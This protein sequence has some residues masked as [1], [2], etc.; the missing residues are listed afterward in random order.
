MR[1]AAAARTTT[2]TTGRSAATATSARRPVAPAGR[3]S[4]TATSRGPKAAPAVIKAASKLSVVKSTP[5]PRAP[6]RTPQLV[7]K[8]AP[9]KAPTPI[10]A[11]TP[12]APPAPVPV[13]P[14]TSQFRQLLMTR[15][16]ELSGNLEDTKFDTLARMG[17][18]A[19][20][21][22][23][24]IS[25]EEF[26]SLQRNSMDYQALRQVNAALERINTGEYGICANCEEP[27]SEKRLKAIPWA[28]YCV[29]CQDRVQA[30][31]GSDD[32][33]DDSAS[34]EAW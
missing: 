1:K 19:E 23:A 28:K 6:Q 2:A 10:A 18:V 20:D 7:V 30:Q 33:D 3:A 31:G 32:S 24:Q 17:R 13:D 11:S 12:I 9:A 29:I 21:D 5:A 8:R 4:N 26:I 27:I 16:Q 22:Q 25:H 14:R 34:S 15:R